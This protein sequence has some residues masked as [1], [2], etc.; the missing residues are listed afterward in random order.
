M[1][2]IELSDDFFPESSVAETASRGTDQREN[3]AVEELLSGPT[4]V[5][6]KSPGP[7]SR[8][9]GPASQ[10]RPHGSSWMSL[11]TLPAAVTVGLCSVAVALFRSTLPRR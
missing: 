9:A 6:A 7:K 3:Q 5:Q 11:F 1:K 10:P 2:K 4:P 8:A